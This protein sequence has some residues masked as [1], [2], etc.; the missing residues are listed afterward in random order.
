MKQAAAIIG[1]GFVGRAHLESLRRIGIPVRGMLGG[2]R[3]RGEETRASLGLERAYASLEELAAD[4]SVTVVHIC[5]PNYVH[6]EQA[7]ALLRAGK[8]VLCEKP[9]AMD[10]RESEML[11]KLERECRRVG[12]VAYNL[13]YYP[14]CQEAKAA[15][16]D[17]RI[18][19]PRLVHG[20]FLQDWLL[21]PTDWNWR[22]DPKLGGELRA[23]SDIGTHWLDLMMWITGRKVTEVCADL[24]T[25]VPV[26]QRPRGRVETFQKAAN[27]EREE[28]LVTT[29]DY[30]SVLLHFEDDLRGVM[31]V[32]Q[33]SAG[34][35]AS[36][37]F[38][39]DGTKGSLAWDSEEPN[40]MWAGGRDEPSEIV[41]KDPVH[42]SPAARVFAAYPAGHAEGY[43]DTFV[44]LF[45]EYYAYLNA[46]DFDAP[47][48]FPTFAAGDH[49]LILCEAI[50][51]SAQSRAWVQVPWE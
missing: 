9:L 40:S 22:L 32:S 25:V 38:E 49:E 35:K 20:G 36:L 39:V 42:Q 41:L 37:T 13:R 15:V 12:A 16:A 46:G 7:S 23:V 34:R 8:H 43:P 44:Q 30:A 18:G 1:L 19:Q 3:E 47:R 50:A 14:L 6:F 29:D 11:V 33:V 5:T 48:K 10:S 26:R 51:K 24:A 28:V 17:G 27:V 2:S 4:P 31:T 21:F 45:R